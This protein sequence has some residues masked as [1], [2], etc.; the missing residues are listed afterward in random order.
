MNVFLSYRLSDKDAVS[1]LTD[2]VKA[3]APNITFLFHESSHEE[4]SKWKKSVEA[5]ID[6]SEKVLFL[7]GKTAGNSDAIKWELQLVLSKNI[8]FRIVG[9]MGKQHLPSYT[10]PFQEH[11]SLRDP[12][13]LNRFLLSSS[14]LITPDDL[15]VEQYKMMVSSTEK[16][17]EQRLKTNNLFFTVTSTI[18]SFSA[19]VGKEFEFN[20]IGLVLMIALATIALVC[21]FFWKRM[22]NS[23]GCLNTGKFKVIAEIEDKLKTNLFQREWDVLIN[24]IRY[25]SNTKT[26]INIVRVYRLFITGVVI[27]EAIVF[28]F[29]NFKSEI[30]C[31]REFL[32]HVL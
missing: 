9:L 2:T 12:K 23:Y 25:R 24:E 18:L 20:E 31:L 10:T 6:S 26:E 16:V 22:I 27:T 32:H 1:K 14:T 17:T 8:P 5:K 7:L 11:I 3:S 4:E 28:L 29:I 15:L 21:T 13:E 30:L 19:L